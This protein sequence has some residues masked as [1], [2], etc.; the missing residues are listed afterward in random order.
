MIVVNDKHQRK[1]SPQLLLVISCVSTTMIVLA[2]KTMP[3]IGA[4]IT[5][6]SEWVR[7]RLK[8]PATRLLTQLFILAQIKE[9]NQTPASLAFVQGIH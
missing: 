4:S 8:S 1:F 2:A 3:V 7:W 6:T 9:K 5:V